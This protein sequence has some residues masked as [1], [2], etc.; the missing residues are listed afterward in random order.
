PTGFEIEKNV[1]E[2]KIDTKFGSYSLSSKATEGNKIVI[3]R[4]FELNDGEFPAEE[5]VAFADFL[6]KVRKADKQKMALVMTKE[7]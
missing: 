5:Y 6:K 4:R 1:K 7:P 2:T 3:E